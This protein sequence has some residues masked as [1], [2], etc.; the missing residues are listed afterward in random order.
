MHGE[1]FPW[2][3]VIQEFKSDDEVKNTP[4]ELLKNS[5]GSSNTSANIAVLDKWY[6]A[7]HKVRKRILE[8]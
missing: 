3:E 5:T 4:L 8:H 6:S 2:F 1:G 7:V